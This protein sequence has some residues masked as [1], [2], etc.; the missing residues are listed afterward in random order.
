MARIFLV[1][2]DPQVGELVKRFLEKEGLLV[3]WARTGREALK[4][5]WEGTKPDLVVLDRGLPDL[6]SLEVL[7]SLRDLDPLLP[8]LLTGRA[9][10]DSR[11][12]GLLE[13]ADDYLG[14]PFSL[15]ELLARIKALLRRGGKEGRRY[16]GPLE[17]DLEAR[18]AYL[19]GQPLKL[20]AT[21]ANLL[22]VLAQTPGRVYTREELLARVWGPEF[23]G[24]ERVVDAYIRLLRKK[25]KDDPQAPRFIETVVGM[26]YRFL[27]E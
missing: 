16:F 10:E 25:L 26:G 27:G 18:K 19:D 2:D 7:R 21:E 11:V 12:E 17:L 23:E 13:G 8:V 9:E 15:K 14:K 4:Q 1:E 20:S 3:V 24:S 22:F 5:A 6:E